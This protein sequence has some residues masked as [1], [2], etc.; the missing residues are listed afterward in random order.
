MP[1]MALEDPDAPQRP[2]EA[3]EHADQQFD[4]YRCARSEPLQCLIRGVVG[5]IQVYESHY[6]LRE[7][8]RRAKDHL[9][10]MAAVDA[11]ICNAARRWFLFPGAWV[12]IPLGKSV[13]GRKPGRYRPAL[14]KTLP[15]ILKILASPELRLIEIRK[16]TRGAKG[17]G[18]G[19]LTTF[20]ATKYLVSLIVSHNVELSHI[21]QRPEQETIV[22]KGP[23]QR[24]TSALVD[25]VDCERT[26]R[27]RAEM[28][29]INRYLASANVDLNPDAVSTSVD[30]SD[31][32][33][34]RY[35]NNGSFDQG[36]RLF[37][38]FWQA[39]PKDER[40]EAI[41]IDNEPIVVLDYSQMGVRLLYALEGLKPPSGDSYL[42]PPPPWW[43]PSVPY[44]PREGMKKVLNAM[45]CR[46]GRLI[47]MP[48]NTRK[49]FSRVHRGVKAADVVAALTRHHGLVGHRFCVGYG[50]RIMRAESDILVAVLLA[51]IDEGITALPIHDAVVVPRSKAAKAADIMR[52][53]FK[54]QTGAWIEVRQEVSEPNVS[55]L[56][57]LR[58]RTAFP[59]AGI[60]EVRRGG[61][62]CVNHGYPLEGPVT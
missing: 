39:I 54:Q 34:H 7:R 41:T 12:A 36:G 6:R 2:D 44:W 8:R 27:E 18:T 22:L 13:I 43:A 57:G 30:P 46:E 40:Y 59:I 49:F 37:G 5:T 48:R 15:T 29:R 61:P 33:L 1:A 60:E 9:T 21:G 20:R 23:K 3:C 10:L 24:G 38:G 42:P 25:Y 47:R 31:R 56:G 32:L 45:L 19:R 62:T 53:V 58:D 51:L 52:Q 17:I 50:L 55:C 16:G 26:S 11:I 14:P 4:P 35:F 28:L